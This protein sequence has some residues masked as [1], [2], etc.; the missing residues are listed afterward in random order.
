MVGAQMMRGYWVDALVIAVV[1]LL[2]SM[3]SRFMYY[4]ELADEGLEIHSIR[5]RVVPWHHIDS[6]TTG[7][8]WGGRYVAVHDAR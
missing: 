7:D 1:V 4:V 2:V 8:R 5:R 6:V 3:L